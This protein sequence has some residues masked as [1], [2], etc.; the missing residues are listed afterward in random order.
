MTSDDH[1]DTVYARRLVRKGLLDKGVL[2]RLDEGVFKTLLDEG[3]VKPEDI[4]EFLE[5][6]FWAVARCTACGT[7]ALTSILSFAEATCEQCDGRMEAAQDAE[8]LKPLRFAANM[9]PLAGRKLAQYD[10]EQ[11]VGQGANAVVYR[12]KHTGLGRVVALKILRP[13]FARRNVRYIDRLKREAQMIAQMRHPNI[14]E[15]YDVGEAG[16]LYFMAMEFIPGGSLGDRLDRLN[17]LWEEEALRIT[18]DITHALVSAHSLGLVHLD[19]KPDNIMID[20][21]GRAKLSDFGLAR[22]MELA[23]VG[24]GDKI[25]GTAAYMSPEQSRNE[26]MDERSDIYSLGVT[27]FRALVGRNPYTGS[28]RQQMRQH[29]AKRNM[30]RVRA[31]M[32]DVS[33]EA[34]AIVWKMVRKRKKARYQSAV[35]VSDDIEGVSHGQ[36]PNALVERLERRRRR[37]RSG[38]PRSEDGSRT[39]FMVRPTKRAVTEDEGPP[40]PASMPQTT[41]YVGIVIFTIA[42]I[43]LVIVLIASLGFF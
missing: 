12:A 13:N 36:T 32:P 42:L 8:A 23:D 35:E 16:G 5:S 2:D 29:A 11:Y 18:L 3:L 22:E 27:L 37:G 1:L 7:V 39:A 6:R 19:I 10:I 38:G 4:R 43:I 26:P 30:P 28:T 15:V 24:I 17:S 20:E 41:V 25:R 14:V 31:Y 33:Q 40:K 21:Q 9:D 34:D